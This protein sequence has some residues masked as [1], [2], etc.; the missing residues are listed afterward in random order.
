M[1]RS[2][3]THRQSSFPRIA[4]IAVGILVGGA[5]ALL[6]L[7]FQRPATRI[8]EVYEVSVNVGP[9]NGVADPGQTTSSNQD[10]VIGMNNA[11]LYL[12]YDAINVVGT[13]S[14]IARHP[15][16]FSV[17]GEDEWNRPIIV[18]IEFRD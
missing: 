4:Q 5:Y 1:N 17:V 10:I 9:A 12:P 3:S 6:I 14:M 16:S 11:V 2:V 18:D 8:P 15:D 13:V 7:Q